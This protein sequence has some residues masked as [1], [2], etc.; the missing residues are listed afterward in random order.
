VIVTT[1]P[2]AL[3]VIEHTLIPLKDGMTLAARTNVDPDAN[4]SSVEQTV[5]LL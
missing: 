3:R 1:F 2:R 4:R 5:R